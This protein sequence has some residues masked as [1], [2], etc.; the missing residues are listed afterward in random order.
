M[1]ELRKREGKNKFKQ[2]KTQTSTSED[3]TVQSS[4]ESRG[5]AGTSSRVSQSERSL[6]GK[7]TSTQSNRERVNIA[8]QI[9][10]VV[11][12]RQVTPTGPGGASC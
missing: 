10:F 5:Q 9:T 11:P 8:M 2:I 12:I 1:A 6:T 7:T 3:E 4:S